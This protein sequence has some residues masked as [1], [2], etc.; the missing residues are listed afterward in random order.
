MKARATWNLLCLI[1]SVYSRIS[2]SLPSSSAHDCS[3]Q[4][5]QP[6]LHSAAST[7]IAVISGNFVTTTYYS[8]L[9]QVV[10]HAKGE[11]ENSHLAILTQL[12]AYCFTVVDCFERMDEDAAQGF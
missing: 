7:I 9:V 1:V 12:A 10:C 8:G 5:M 11:S 2:P 3:S 4:H 6:I